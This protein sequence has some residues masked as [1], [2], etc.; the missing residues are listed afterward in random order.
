MV[1]SLWAQEKR[2]PVCAYLINRIV[3]CQKW[4][5]ARGSSA[6]VPSF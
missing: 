4:H 1:F 2:D 3:L 5:D 6:S